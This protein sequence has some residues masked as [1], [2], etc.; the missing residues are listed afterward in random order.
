M[1]YFILIVCFTLLI[2][3]GP[4]HLFRFKQCSGELILLWQQLV[5][6]VINKN[7]IPEF[8]F[9]LQIQ[10]VPLKKE[11]WLPLIVKWARFC[12]A[13]QHL[14]M[15]DP[16]LSWPTLFFLLSPHKDTKQEGIIMTLTTACCSHLF[17]E[18]LPW[19]ILWSSETHLL[20]LRHS[21]DLKCPRNSPTP[22][23]AVWKR[24]SPG[25]NPLIS[26][27]GHSHTGPRW[28]SFWFFERW[29]SA[30]HL[31]MEA[32]REKI[33]SVD[34]HAK[35]LRSLNTPGK[36][37]K[38]KNLTRLFCELLRDRRNHLVCDPLWYLMQQF[39]L[40]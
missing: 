32:G 40:L 34:A 19:Q 18:P 17:C 13:C 12:S 6:S 2:F 31:S 15:A 27:K 8:E 29:T 10:I 28:Q 7:E 9:L 16:L 1:L 33:N 21:R 11:T 26:I 37:R 22:P 23:P 38:R 24:T 5:Y 25:R 3:G 30:H 39:P 35:A 36:R 4:C 20:L 14:N